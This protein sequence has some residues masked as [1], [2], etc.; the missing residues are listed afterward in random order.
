LGAVTFFNVQHINQAVQIEAGWKIVQIAAGRYS[1]ESLTLWASDGVL[2][3]TRIIPL[4]QTVQ[5][6]GVQTG[7]VPGILKNVRTHWTRHF[8]TETVKQRLDI[9]GVLT[10]K[11]ALT[12][13]ALHNTQ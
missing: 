4:F 13:E 9:H 10:N 7:K 8:F 12:F 6:E 1:T 3:V 2:K 11:P 5:T